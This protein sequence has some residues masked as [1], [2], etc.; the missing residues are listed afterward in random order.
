[1]F[2]II[3][4]DTNDAGL[5]PLTSRLPHALLPLVGKPILVHLLEQLHRN[6]I[7][8]VMVVSP[9][10]HER[11]A[12]SIDTGPLLGMRISFA[13]GL[14]DLR[15]NPDETLVIGSRYLVDLNWRL[16]T[17]GLSESNGQENSMM[18]TSSARPVALIVPP[19]AS[20]LVPDNWID[21]EQ[22]LIPRVPVDNPPVL[23]I[24]SLKNYVESSFRLLNE[25]L[26]HFFPAGRQ[27]MAG[28]YVSPKATVKP[29]SLQSNNAYVGSYSR[30]DATAT[31]HGDV[32][33]GEKVVIDRGASI[34]NSI[35]LDGTYVGAMTRCH[36]AI[37]HQNLLIRVDS[38]ISVEINDPVLVSAC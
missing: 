19:G 30:I 29:Q 5:E 6:N 26:Q 37:I 10:H 1:M 34:S 24:D 18:I 36:N 15:R 12:T 2:A 8:D 14:P 25:K 33:V 21:V 23:S 16:I 17:E 28:L 3:L 9:D 35:I 20:D 31:L 22:M 13:A 38:G 27:N 32:V 11:L 7:M 4:A